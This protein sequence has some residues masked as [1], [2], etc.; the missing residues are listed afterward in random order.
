MSLDDIANIHFGHLKRPKN[1][2]NNVLNRLYRDGRI[3]R[4]T[5]VQPYLYFGPDT[6]IKENSAKIGHYLAI[7]DTYKDI[8]KQGPISIF[9]VEPKYGPK[10]TV[11]PDVFSIALRTPF[12]M[13]VQNTIYSDKLMK[14]KM[15]R[16]EKFYESGIITKE[17]WQPKGKEPILPCVIIITQHR[18]AIS[19][20][21]S[22][23]IFQAESF[24]QFLE[25]VK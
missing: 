7:V 23:E 10:G 20:N 9:N 15:D 1:S 4:S 22:F 8:L 5:K 24:S 6:N 12:F 16:Y 11:E 19:N 25:S 13:E 17:P 18:Y 2:A 21:Y 14:E 3:K